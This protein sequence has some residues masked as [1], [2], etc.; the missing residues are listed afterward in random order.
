MKLDNFGKATAHERFSTDAFLQLISKV[1]SV[2]FLA[3]F[4]VYISAIDPSRTDEFVHAL[5]NL[6]GF[7]PY[8]FGNVCLQLVS[9]RMRSPKPLECLV[10][11]GCPSPGS[12]FE[13]LEEL[14]LYPEAATPALSTAKSL[15]RIW[16]QIGADIDLATTKNVI[17]QIFTGGQTSLE[18]LRVRVCKQHADNVLLEISK[19]LFH[20]DGQRKYIDITLDIEKDTSV[21]VVDRLQGINAILN[22]LH[23]S[24]IQDYALR[25][26][27][28]HDPCV[29]AAARRA[30]DR[31]EQLNGK[32][33][34]MTVD[35]K[36]YRYYFIK[37][38]SNRVRCFDARP[39]LLPSL[40]L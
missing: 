11:N 5:P 13:H 40:V 32:R 12:N 22:G 15:K 7:C 19:T 2:Q 20:V 16:I 39:W 30:V 6:R 1:P 26:T 4:S 14:L 35:V 28:F 37:K 34:N 10:C 38:G 36:Q 33:F 23:S 17:R 8:G 9:L 27:K 31:F 24:T 3:M 18:Q 29:D 25:V 21:S